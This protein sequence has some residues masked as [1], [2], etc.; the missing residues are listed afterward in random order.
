MH[1]LD[2]REQCSAENDR[3]AGGQGLT[4]R[5]Q[6]MFAGEEVGFYSDGAK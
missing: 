2:R 1:I 5:G 6:L 4:G 3:Q